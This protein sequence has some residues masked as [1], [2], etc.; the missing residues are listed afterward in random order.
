MVKLRA[1]VVGFGSIAQRHIANLRAGGG[2]GDIIVVR[3]SGRPADAPRD[4]RFVDDVVE[5]L[6]ARPQLAIIA[7]PS[8]AHAAALLPILGAR[9]PCYVE[10]PPV[11]SENDLQRV[12]ALLDGSEPL[13]MTGCNLRFLPSLQ[14]MREAL[15]RGDAGV[16]VRA[17]FEAGQWLP[18]WRRGRDYRASYSARADDGGGVLLDL[19]HE[20]DCARWFF[21][22]FDRVLA[23]SARL[24][25]LEISA[26]DTACV[27]LGRERGPFVTVA[28]DYV[29][30]QRIR[31]YE[32]VGDE[33]TL[34]WDLGA[35]SLTLTTPKEVRVLDQTAEGFD[36]DATYRS[37]MA[38]FLGGVRGGA[39]PAPDLREGL[40]STE[41]VLR[42]KAS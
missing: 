30:R 11:T 13:T 23:L 21:G 14:K 6:A 33:G 15:K 27:L 32:I 25:R 20:F 2:V 16:P 26:E 41:L 34:E 35:R 12:L 1:L 42:A 22:E 29:A 39:R 40:A 18:D 36:T 28:V 17:S 31:R 8:A 4:L 24:R 38:C 19:V 37:A 10:K 3:P 7:S 5:G 9:V